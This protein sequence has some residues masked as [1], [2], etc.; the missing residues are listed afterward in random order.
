M[1]LSIKEMEVRK[2]PFAETWQ[3]GGIDFSDSGAQQASPL[4]TRGEAELLANTGN[5][6]RVK[7]RVEVTLETE[8][9]RCLGRAQFPIDTPFD[10][11]YK[12][13]EALKETD[14]EVA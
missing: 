2:L 4:N 14:D 7:G 8:C 12:P 3:P 6:V 13:I 10:L 1:L 11:F 5:E 9:D